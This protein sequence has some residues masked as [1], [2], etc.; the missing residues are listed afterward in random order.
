M[1]V[2]VRSAVSDEVPQYASPPDK[3][4]TSGI[5]PRI[6]EQMTQE[7]AQMKEGKGGYRMV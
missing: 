4:T 1:P 7:L 3:I 6:F 5:T 2:D